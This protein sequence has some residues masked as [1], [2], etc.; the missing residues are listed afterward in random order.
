MKSEKPMK[1][2]LFGEGLMHPS[3][4]GSKRF[5]VRKY[6]G[7]RHDFEKGEVII[8]EFMDGLDILI[9]AT[10]RTIKMPFHRLAAR[11]A[12]KDGQDWWFNDE[13]FEDLKRFPGYEDINPVTMGAVICFEVLKV[14]GVPAVQFNKHSKKK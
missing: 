9:R 7:E 1:R 2:L 6:G 8:G 3:L 14:N 11:G 5:T 13:Y 12:K 10:E 4:D